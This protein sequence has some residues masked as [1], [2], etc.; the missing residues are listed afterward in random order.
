MDGDERYDAQEAFVGLFA[1][2]FVILVIIAVRRIVGR[3]YELVVFDVFV[4]L[5]GPVMSVH[6]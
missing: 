6:G 2:V 5:R 1:T 4:G 3:P